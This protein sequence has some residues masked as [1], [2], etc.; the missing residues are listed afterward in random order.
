MLYLFVKPRPE[1]SLLA[2]LKL[3][4]LRRRAFNCNAVLLQTVFK[5][6]RKTRPDRKELIVSAKL[7][8]WNNL[9]SEPGLT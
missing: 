8:F 9:R 4:E 3:G 6:A 2:G 1:V 5:A 7:E